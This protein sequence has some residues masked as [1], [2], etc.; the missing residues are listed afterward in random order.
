[1]VTL[2]SLTLSPLKEWEKPWRPPVGASSLSGTGGNRGIIKT[3]KPPLA[4]R[5]TRPPGNAS[6]NDG[7][8]HGPLTAF[9]LEFVK[10]SI[11]TCSARTLSFK[12]AISQAYCLHAAFLASISRVRRSIRSFMSLSSSVIRH[13]LNETNAAHFLWNGRYLFGLE[14]ARNTFAHAP[15]E[16]THLVRGDPPPQLSTD[17]M[18]QY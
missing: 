3:G 13:Q 5:T 10:L 14:S 1:M 11:L 15:M 17:T 8:G 9:R 4:S 2:P 12:Q 6:S 7:G 18:V 16:R